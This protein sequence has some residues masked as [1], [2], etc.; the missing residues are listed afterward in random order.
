MVCWDLGGKAELRSLW[1]TYFHDAHGVIFVIDASD[2]ARF[3]EALHLIAVVAQQ[4]TSQRMPLLVVVNKQDRAADP[5]LNARIDA[6][7]NKAA[8]EPADVRRY[9][10]LQP[11]VASSGQGVSLG[12]QWIIN[13]LVELY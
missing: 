11:A 6:T 4:C 7:M 12:M 13:R 5:S 8:M 1:E 3:N 2:S 10:K 9:C